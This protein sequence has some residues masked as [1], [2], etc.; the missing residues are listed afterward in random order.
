MNVR[1]EYV[2][3]LRDAAG[4]SGEALEVPASTTV[5]EL[6]RKVAATRGA[7]LAGLLLDP[8]GAPRATVLVFVGEAQVD[9]DAP[10]DL[11]EGDVVTLMSPLAGG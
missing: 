8:E 11:R 9:A 4:V 6:L 3:Q 10:Q 5:P 2:A 1:I 7:R